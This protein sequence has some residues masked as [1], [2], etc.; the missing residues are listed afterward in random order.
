[1]SINSRRKVENNK[2]TGSGQVVT[3]GHNMTSPNKPKNM[4]KGRR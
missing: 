4:K 2:R 3:G 1:M